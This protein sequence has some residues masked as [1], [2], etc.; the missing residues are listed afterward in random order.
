M[1]MMTPIMPLKYPDR[2]SDNPCYIPAPDEHGKRDWTSGL[3]HHGT[4]A[5][6]AHAPAD[7]LLLR[8][9]HAQEGKAHGVPARDQ[10]ARGVRGPISAWTALA[11]AHFFP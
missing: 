4:R 5:V 6:R 1:A 11:L 2:P 3:G 9:P 7:V 10:R 8:H